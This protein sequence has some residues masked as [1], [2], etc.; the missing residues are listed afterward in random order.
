MISFYFYTCI[1]DGI[2]TAHVVVH[3]N[4]QADH[5]MQ[6]NE[7]ERPYLDL[8]L[9][10]GPIT[11]ITTTVVECDEGGSS[12]YGSHHPVGGC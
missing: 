11:N 2:T 4:P 9:T 5:G 3:T 12:S 8:T 1:V 10:C 7:L 6:S